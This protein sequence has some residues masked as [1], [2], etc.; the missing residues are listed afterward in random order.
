M[1]DNVVSINLYKPHIC[2]NALCLQC[3][4]K[5]VAC[6]PVGT[7]ELQCSE[8]NT[9]KGVF[10]WMTA[11]DTVWECRCGNQHFFINEAGAMCAMCGFYHEDF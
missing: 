2:G 5:W 8:C 11:P 9:W 6:A 4:N 1:I 7:T 3:D 10:E